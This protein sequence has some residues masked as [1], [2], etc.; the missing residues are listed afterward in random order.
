[1]GRV[2]LILILSAVSFRMA[3]ATGNSFSNCVPNFQLTL[4]GQP[5]PQFQQCIAQAYQQQLLQFQQQQPQWWQA[6]QQQLQQ[7]QLT[8][9]GNSQGS[10]SEKCKKAAQNF[11]MATQAPPSVVWNFYITCIQNPAAFQNAGGPNSQIFP[12]GVQGAGIPGGIVPSGADQLYPDTIQVVMPMP[13]G[14]PT[15]GPQGGPGQPNFHWP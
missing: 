6:Y 14:F 2:F 4:Q 11:M 13:G 12:G 1:M 9:T 10:N 3:W 7:Q 8:Q 5:D 15:G